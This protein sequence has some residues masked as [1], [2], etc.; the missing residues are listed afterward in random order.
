MHLLLVRDDQSHPMCQSVTLA[1]LQVQL[2]GYEEAR[3][4][5]LNNEMNP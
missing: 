5:L 2:I 1:S 3:L 4:P